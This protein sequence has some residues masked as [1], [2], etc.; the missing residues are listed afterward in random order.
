MSGYRYDVF[1]SYTRRAGNSLRWVR[2]HLH[3]RLVDC[4][5]DQLGNSPTVYLDKAMERGVHWPTDIADALRRSKILIPI[6]T[7]PYFWSPWCTAEWHS[8]R[9]R[10]EML[11]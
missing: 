9:K 7:P 6:C 8:M 3:P 2:N 11:G 1:I 10:E 5:G 4:L